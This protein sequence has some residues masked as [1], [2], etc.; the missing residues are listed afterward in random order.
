MNTASQSPW[1]PV[2]GLS[3]QLQY[4]W[5][6]SLLS[7]VS[8]QGFTPFHRQVIF[9]CTF[10][11]Y[12]FLHQLIHV[13]TV[14]ISWLLMSSAL[15]NICLQILGGVDKI[16]NLLDIFYPESFALNLLFE[17]P[18]TIARWPFSS[19]THIVNSWHNKTH[20]QYQNN[21]KVWEGGDVCL[22]VAGSCWC[23][24]ETITIL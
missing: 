23:M 5:G 16:T 8:H 13:R 7:H 21:N 9:H 12:L 4:C 22:P 6:S 15:M 20:A 10:S 2:P 1:F 24:A 18:V 3:H 14:S 11:L 17:L 19:F